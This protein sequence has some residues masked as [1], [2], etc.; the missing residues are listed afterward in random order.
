MKKISERDRDVDRRNTHSLL[1]FLVFFLC[2]VLVSFL[3]VPECCAKP[4]VAVPTKG[5][6]KKSEMQ[7]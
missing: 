2:S 3:V 5:Q 6:V 1:F 7:T 4:P